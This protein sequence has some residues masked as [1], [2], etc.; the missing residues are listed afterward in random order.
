MKSLLGKQKGVSLIEVLVAVAVVSI[1]L[2]GVGALQGMSLRNNNNSYFRTQ[3][4]VMAYQVLDEVRSNRREIIFRGG[5]R[6]DQFD[7]WEES[8]ENLFPNGE[9]EIT[10][11]GDGN[12][13]CNAV[14]CEIIKIRI[15]WT[16]QVQTGNNDASQATA[17][18]YDSSDADLQWFE[19]ESRI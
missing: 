10:D 6:T 15:R 14:A 12:W 3:A 1:G 5:W 17:A 13:S 9:L 8:V 2:L 7:E 11:Q 4:T 18:G 19:L 16:D